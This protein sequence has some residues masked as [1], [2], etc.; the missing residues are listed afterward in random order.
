MKRATS[1]KPGTGQTLAATHDPQEV[2]AAARQAQ[3]VASAAVREAIDKA[4][5]MNARLAAAT[6]EHAA[7]VAAANAAANAVVSAKAKLANAEDDVTARTAVLE[8]RQNDPDAKPGQVETARTALNKAVRA[9]SE[10]E[11]ALISAEGGNQEAAN[12]VAECEE[13]LATVRGEPAV[14]HSSVLKARAALD[15]ADAK[16]RQA[17]AAVLVAE[18]QQEEAA[19]P[20]PRFASVDAFVQAYVLPNWRHSRSDRQNHW[21]YQWWKHAEAITRFEAL[22]EAFEVA[23]REPPPAMSLFWVQQ[24]DHHLSLLTAADGTFAQCGQHDQVEHHVP[25]PLWP[26]DPAPKGLFEVDDRAKVQPV[27]SEPQHQEGAAA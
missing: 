5:A 18:K 19:D 12:R 4:P 1:A 17:E 22:W 3:I 23:R 14:E 7:A 26:C 9:Q 13:R 16:V 2:L 15:A 20:V 11:A 25:A 8:D 27:Q 21:C 24:V 10:A 6:Q